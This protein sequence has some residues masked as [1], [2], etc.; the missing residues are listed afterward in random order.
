MSHH[1]QLSPEAIQQLKA[2]KRNSTIS[3]IIIAL[4]L[5]ALI[6]AVLFF[7]ALS[8]IFK[9]EEELI[10]YS[11][12]SEIIE[13]ITEPEKTSEVEK[14]P[15]SPSS[16][17]SK[18]I[19]ASTPSPT[20]IPI[21]V[22][23]ADEP[24]LEFGNSSDFGG[25][26]GGS[27]FGSGTAGSGRSTPFGRTG[28]SGLKGSFYDLKQDRNRE[29]TKLAEVYAGEGASGRVKNNAY[30]KEIAR[31]NRAKYSQ[32]SL[33]DTFKADVELT[34]THLAISN[35]KASI[36]PEAFNVEKEVKPSAWLIVYEGV[37]SQDAPKKIRFTGRF[38]DLIIVYINDK[39]VFDGSWDDYTGKLNKENEIPGPS[40]IKR[41]MIQG[42]KFISFKKG[43]KIRIL[44]GEA[45]GGYLGGG[46][47]VAEEGVKYKKNDDGQDILPPFTSQ[48]LTSEDIKKLKKTKYPMELNDVPV[49]SME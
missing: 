39:I 44:V 23:T 27:D 48:P 32:S 14:K 26:W 45:P 6:V 38:D 12:A 31:L 16:A 28:G 34:F 4:L 20:A 29:A 24:S 3:A 37:I 33:R 46:L 22:D 18:V 19:S 2:Q 21:P 42:D 43:D 41:P 11:P 35:A 9:N 36:A 5:S 40:L 17:I 13:E 47:F 10:S 30:K 15:S 8:P 25:G 1:A 7:I 49:F